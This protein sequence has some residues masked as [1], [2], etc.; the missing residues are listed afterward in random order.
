MSGITSVNGG[1]CA[2]VLIG[3]FVGA[4]TAPQLASVR[5]GAFKPTAYQ[6]KP[7]YSFQG[8][9]TG[10]EDEKIDDR[11]YKIGAVASEVTTQDQTENIALVRAAEIAGANGYTHF[12]VIEKKSGVI[13]EGPAANPFVDLK[14]QLRKADE[15]A[16]LGKSYEASDVMRTKGL[17]ITRTDGSKEGKKR[18]YIANLMGCNTGVQQDPAK[19]KI[20]D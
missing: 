11:T 9:A 13:C 7:S 8:P 10:Y 20:E 4:C 17:D 12:T 14:V 3:L 15:A 19:M 6:E 16:P 5:V 18:A 2:V 1:L